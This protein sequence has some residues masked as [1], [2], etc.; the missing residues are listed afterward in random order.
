MSYQWF[1]NFAH[2]DKFVSFSDED[3]KTIPYPKTELLVHVAYKTAE[4]GCFLGS[5]LVGPVYSII[6]RGT[7]FRSMATK[8][9]LGGLVAGVLVAPVMVHYRLKQVEATPEAIYDRCY[10]IRHNEKQLFID[11][12]VTLLAAGGFLADRWTGVVLGIDCAIVGT[13]LF[14]AFLWDRFAKKTDV[15]HPT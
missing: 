6:R 12:S 15:R 3:M 8:C 9:G 13:L 7:S 14:N 2:L 1:V 11:R 10:R 5:A 4:V